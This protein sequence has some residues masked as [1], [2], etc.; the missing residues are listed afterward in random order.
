[1]PGDLQTAT[2]CPATFAK[3]RATM[4]ILINILILLAEI[5]LQVSH[6][7]LMQR[8]NVYV[9]IILIIWLEF[10]EFR[11]LYFPHNHRVRVL[12]SVLLKF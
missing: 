4:V 8:F 3:R 6:R 2:S 9:V 12:S 10:R 11:E 7:L 5:A 1:M